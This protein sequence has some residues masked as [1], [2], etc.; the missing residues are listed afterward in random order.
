MLSLQKKKQF[1]FSVIFCNKQMHFI[2]SFQREICLN[3]SIS[4]FYTIEAFALRDL[5]SISFLFFFFFWSV[6]FVATYL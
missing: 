4:N 3:F 1:I 5:W 6:P 2:N